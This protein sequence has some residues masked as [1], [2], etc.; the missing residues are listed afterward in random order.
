MLKKEHNFNGIEYSVYGEPVFDFNQ[1]IPETCKKCQHAIEVSPCVDYKI[2]EIFRADHMV[3]IKLK[4]VLALR[5]RKEL[6]TKTN[7][8][9]RICEHC[10]ELEYQEL[11]EAATM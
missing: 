2:T 8:D 7:E 3:K 10:L 1:S 4:S 5:I 6:I 9:H 11:K